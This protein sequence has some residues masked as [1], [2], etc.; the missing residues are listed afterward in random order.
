MHATLDCTFFV[1]YKQG[2]FLLIMGLPMVVISELNLTSLHKVYL[3]AL[4]CKLLRHNY[5]IEL[6]IPHY[7]RHGGT[8][9]CHEFHVH[10]IAL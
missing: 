8:R 5:F 9:V 6:S 7:E 1:G 2:L 4:H 10:S 3:T